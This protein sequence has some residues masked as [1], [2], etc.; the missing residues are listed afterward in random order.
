MLNYFFD[1]PH[2]LLGFQSENHTVWQDQLYRLEAHFMLRI[3]GDL[4]EIILGLGTVTG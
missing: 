3:Q 1:E 2:L 4:D